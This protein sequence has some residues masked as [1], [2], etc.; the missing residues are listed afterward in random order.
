[1]NEKPLTETDLEKV[2]GGNLTGDAFIATLDTK[3]E[4]NANYLKWLG[5]NKLEASD[6]TLSLYR[7]Q[8]NSNSTNE[9]VNTQLNSKP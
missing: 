9:W 3:N 5:G 6:V 2:V 1:M 4:D 7:T 8:V